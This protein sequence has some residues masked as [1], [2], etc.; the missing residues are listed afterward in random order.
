MQCRYESRN[1]SRDIGS[2]LESF[3]FIFLP[4]GFRNAAA[5]GAKEVV[6]HVGM[7]VEIVTIL[8]EVALLGSMLELLVIVV[9]HAD[10]I[11][12]TVRQVAR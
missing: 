2:S 8:Q 4:E 5:I 9:D 7:E 6:G 3:V 11:S 12:L 10:S 1:E